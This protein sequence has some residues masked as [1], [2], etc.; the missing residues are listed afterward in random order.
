MTDPASELRAAVAG[1]VAGGDSG[2]HLTEDEIAAYHAGTLPADAAER[3][4]D[5]LLACRECTDLLLGR[6]ELADEGEPV[7]SAE[8]GA[9]WQRMQSRLPPAAP[10]PLASPAPLPFPR[11]RRQAPV[12]LGALAAS[13][14]V[15]VVGLSAWVASLRR[16]VDELS[17]PQVDTPVVDLFPSPLRGSREEVPVAPLAPD[18]RSFLLVLNPQDQRVFPR[19]EV[20]ITRAGGGAVWQGKLRRD[21]Q[22]GSFRLLL[23]RALMAAGSYEI[24]LWGVGTAGRA[25]LGEYGLKVVTPAERR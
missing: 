9:A 23:P 1:L 2:P 24:R 21:E 13:L 8:L 10:Q 19:Y 11:R 14:L 3:A 18:A 16:T 20:V 22:L 5:H 6:A 12:W 15:A 17:R 4:Q 7:P 25:P